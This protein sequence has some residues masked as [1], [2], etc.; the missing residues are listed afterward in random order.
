MEKL[1]EIREK[2]RPGVE[3]ALASAEEELKQL[4]SQRDGLV[5]ALQQQHL[6]S[7]I[8][9][10][11]YEAMRLAGNH[12]TRARDTD[13]DW[14]TAHNLHNRLVEEIPNIER[15]ISKLDGEITKTR[16][17]IA[18]LREF[19]SNQDEHETAG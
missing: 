9:K 2:H 19:L 15:R 1:A 5:N 12:L 6:T 10:N 17:T 18:T 3:R 11:T 14:H 13:A 16:S 4:T 7:R 8:A